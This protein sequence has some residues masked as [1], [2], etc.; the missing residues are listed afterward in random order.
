M[1]PTIS[2]LTSW[3]NDLCIIHS[4]PHYQYALSAKFTRDVISPLAIQRWMRDS[5]IISKSL[6]K[7]AQKLKHGL[8]D[9]FKLK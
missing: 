6:G 9:N 1:L 8:D 5:F 7:T 3:K 2:D 4:I